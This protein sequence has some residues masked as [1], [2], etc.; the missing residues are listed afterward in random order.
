[1]L[2]RVHLLKLAVEEADWLLGQ[3][4]PQ[5]LGLALPQKPT[6]VGPPVETGC[7]LVDGKLPWATARR[8]GPDGGQDRCGRG[9][10]GG[11]AMHKPS[12]DAPPTTWLWSVQ[13]PLIPSQKLMRLPGFQANPSCG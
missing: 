3:R 6:V 5:A 4:D 2:K 9:L 12:A 8:S 11:A 1:M 13:G 7:D 10:P